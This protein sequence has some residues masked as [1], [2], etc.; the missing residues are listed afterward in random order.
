VSSAAERVPAPAGLATLAGKSIEVLL[1]NQDAGGAYVASPSLPQYRYAWLRDGAFVADSLSRAGEHAS[2][3]AFFRWCAQVLEARAERIDDLVARRRDG[4]EVGPGE[5]LH[6]RYTVAGRESDEPWATFQLD[7]YGAWVWALGAHLE[8]CDAG[9]EPFLDGAALSLRYAAAFWEEPCYDWWEERL[10]LHTA[11]LAAVRAGLIAGAEHGLGPAD[12]WAACA[13]A[14]RER[15]LAEGLHDGR[16]ASEL[17]GRR[18]DA[19]LVA[20]GVPLGL[21]AADDPRMEATVSAIE[22]RLVHGGGGVHRHAEDTYYGGGLWLLLAG[23]LGHHYAE[24]GREEDA[25]AQLEWIAAWA[26]DGGA[27]PE[28]TEEHLLAPEA[29]QFWLRRWGPPADPLLWSHAQFLTLA[30]RLGVEHARAPGGVT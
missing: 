1:A 17:G 4:E 2:A 9:P 29:R 22:E 15:T 18:L 13:E 10:G 30:L 11:T 24:T 27:L 28:Q 21:L 25:R 12:E 19:S 6:A 16:L 23:L 14:I 7:G 26:G 20:C 8:R 3:E 5:H